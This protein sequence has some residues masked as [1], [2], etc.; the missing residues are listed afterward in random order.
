MDYTKTVSDA[1]TLAFMFGG[2]NGEFLDG[3]ANI[4]E[5]LQA[6][7]AELEAAPA[8]PEQ[9]ETEKLAALMQGLEL[10]P[11]AINMPVSFFLETGKAI[12]SQ[13]KQAQT[14]GKVLTDD[15]EKIISDEMDG[16]FAGDYIDSQSA[17]ECMT[18]FAR[19][20]IAASTSKDSVSAVEIEDLKS[21]KR[22]DWYTRNPYRATD[23]LLKALDV[24]KSAFWRIK[25]NEADALY[26][27]E[28]NG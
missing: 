9:N 3:L 1:R 18:N 10:P 25:A 23:I 6:R 2:E 28:N 17:R 21:A 19:A 20:I 11:T 16:Y 12:A 24:N 7:I 27:R 5:S 26:W 15:I 22:W 14:Q 8:Q 4:I 13:A